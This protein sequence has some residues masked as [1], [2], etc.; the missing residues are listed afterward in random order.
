MA[1]K[2]E[3]NRMNKEWHAAHAMPPNPTREQRIVWHAEHAVACACRPVPAS[4]LAEVEAL[5][6]KAR[7]AN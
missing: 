7:R 5:N 6:R 2:A 3:R 1:E 4:L